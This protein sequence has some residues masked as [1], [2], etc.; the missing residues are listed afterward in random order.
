[1]ENASELQYFD[2]YLYSTF[3]LG[4]LLFF[5][6]ENVFSPFIFQPLSV[7]VMGVSDIKLEK[8][9]RLYSKVMEY[10]PHLLMKVIMN[11]TEFVLWLTWLSKFQGWE[12]WRE[13]PTYN[14]PLPL[15]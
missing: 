12:N 7:W 4:P 10:F 14:Q 1:M 9:S 2:P 3:I 15:D 5:L 6:V 11:L 13:W 8:G